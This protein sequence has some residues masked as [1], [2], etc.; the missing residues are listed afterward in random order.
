VP[1][2]IS[3]SSR[4]V[5]YV[6]T[7]A[8]QVLCSS[9]LQNPNSFVNGIAVI[10]KASC[11]CRNQEACKKFPTA[12]LAQPSSFGSW[13]I[14]HSA[15]EPEPRPFVRFQNFVVLSRAVFKGA[16]NDP[17]CFPPP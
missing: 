12:K 7:R 5:L 8:R 17:S 13:P 4:S 16:A 9:S 15:A 6:I 14:A 1:I 10:V 3:S 11:S 2:V